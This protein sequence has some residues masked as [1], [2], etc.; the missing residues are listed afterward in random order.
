MPCP[1]DSD[2]SLHHHTA[3][4]K[5][6]GNTATGSDTLSIDQQSGSY[7]LSSGSMEQQP[8]EEHYVSED[9]N[10]RSNISSD[11]LVIYTMRDLPKPHSVR[12]TKFSCGYC[13]KTFYHRGNFI[14]HLG[15]HTGEKPFSCTFCPFKTSR[16]GNL[17]SHIRSRHMNSIEA[18]SEMVSLLEQPL[19]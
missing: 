6:Q 18:N 1:R 15:T 9:S 13:S 2:I 16:K 7:C 3:H 14:C 11:V 8:V 19:D 4:T 17:E 12:N 5:P 10:S